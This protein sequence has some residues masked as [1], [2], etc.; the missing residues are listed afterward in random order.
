MPVRVRI[1][2]SPTG[3]PHVGTAYVALFNFLL[4]RKDG[5]RFVIR[6]ED[7]DQARKVEG[8]EEAIFASLRWLGLD[9]DE[10]PDLGGA[11]GPYRQS[12]RLG[13]YREQVDR[14][15]KSGAAYLCFCTPERLEALRG[16]QKHRQAPPGYDGRCRH[17]TE[18]E[19]RRKEAEGG[20]RVVRLKVPREGETVFTD[21]LR[22]EI[23]FDNRQID[24]QV[25]L[26]SDGFPTYHLANVVD[27]HL[28]QIT[29]IIRG[30]EW[31]SSVPKHVLLYRALGWEMPVLCHLPLLRNADRSKVSKRKNPTSLLWFRKEGYLP[32]AMLNFL[33]LMGGGLSSDGKEELFSLE[34][35]KQA[36][37][38]SRIGMTG[39]VF[40]LQKLEWL[41]GV[42]MRKLSPEEL[43]RRL[44]AE[45]FAPAERSGE[46]IQK[47]LPLVQER[48]KRL[49]EF[50]P[51]TDFLF[52]DELT[53]DP[54]LLAGKGTPEQARKIL[55]GFRERIECGG[56]IFS[57]EGLEKEV[58][59][60]ASELGSKRGP[61]FM[62][63]RVAVT[64]STAT[65]PIC[66]TMVVLG[67]DKVLERLCRALEF[68]S[69]A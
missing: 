13:I 2:P 32:E 21:L 47:V 9:W 26:K 52:R 63:I 43:A 42:W 53:Y 3:D 24:D 66:D 61:V 41:N 56:T 59:A 31:L 18:E 27:D 10:G 4:A 39:P 54:K 45:G 8:A 11:L 15:L 40:D 44:R 17:L 6:I 38:L 1:A 16:E 67:R 51:L 60:L 33:G 20:S 28:M 35:M 58:D 37:E 14:L 25:L 64:G 5:G 23:R 48:M 29:H 68:L 30:E 49:S 36:F 69:D 7:T 46:E 19:I 57:V 65:P 34:E 62:A 55:A 22:G 50:G 12:E